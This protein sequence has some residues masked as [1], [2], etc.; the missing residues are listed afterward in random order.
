MRNSQWSRREF[1]DRVFWP[2]AYKARAQ[3]VGFNL[4]FDLSRLATAHTY[5]KRSMKGGFS[6][7]FADKRPNIRVKHLSQRAAFINFAGKGSADVSPDRGFFVD[8]KTLAASLLGQ[9]HSVASLSALL[10]TTPKPTD[11]Q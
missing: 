7:T 5:G 9:S 2:I 11:E 10:K 3:V 1:V 6:F 4:P 8:V